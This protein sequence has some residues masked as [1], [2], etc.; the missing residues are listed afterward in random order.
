MRKILSAVL[1]AAALAPAARAADTKIG[2]VDRRRA[3]GEIDEAKAARL[4][5][6]ADAEVKQKE[7]RAK[8]E[9][10]KG[11][12]ADLDRQAAVLDE[13]AKQTK[14]AELDKRVLDARQLLEKYNQD[15][16]EREDQLTGPIIK[17][18]TAIV[19]EIAEADGL[20]MV[21]DQAV[22]VWAAGSLDITNE[23][24]RKYNAKYPAGGATPA[25]AKGGT[26][27]APGAKPK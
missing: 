17:K 1:I 22:V 13:K 2:F 12:Q 18:M 21:V 26:K 11:L 25:P 6:Q 24:I 14:Q 8:E 15:M 27:P 23:V 20:Q 3:L 9:E 4:S 7:L 19:K 5:L 10:L 16:V